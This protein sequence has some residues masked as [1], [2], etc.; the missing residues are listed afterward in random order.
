MR[1]FLDRWRCTFGWLLSFVLLEIVVR[2]VFLA[3]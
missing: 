3:W 1:S 2:G